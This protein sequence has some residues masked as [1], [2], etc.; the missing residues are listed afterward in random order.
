MIK[1]NSQLYST[2]WYTTKSSKAKMK[3]ATRAKVRLEEASQ[4]GHT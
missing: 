3:G 2:K 1:K 4:K